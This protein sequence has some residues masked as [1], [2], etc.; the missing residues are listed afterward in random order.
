MK[1]K[2]GPTSTMLNTYVPASIQS[3]ANI[4]GHERGSLRKCKTRGAINCVVKFGSGEIDYN[5]YV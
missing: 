2:T 5:S 4:L 3:M 1:C